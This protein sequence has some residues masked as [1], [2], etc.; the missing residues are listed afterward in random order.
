MLKPWPDA[1]AGK[2][3]PVDVMACVD[4]VSRLNSVLLKHVRAGV[5]A[6]MGAHTLSIA[7]DKANVGGIGLQADVIVIPSNYAIFCCPQFD[8]VY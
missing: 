2:L 7:F 6:T 3:R 1:I 5:E 8:G 4:D